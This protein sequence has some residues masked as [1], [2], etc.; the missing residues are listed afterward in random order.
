MAL[1]TDVLDWVNQLI[2]D[3][4]IDAFYKSTKWTHK[5][6]QILKDQHYECQRCKANGKVVKARTVHHKKYLKLFP[7]LALDD[8]NLEAICDACHYDEHHK[9]KGYTNDER[10]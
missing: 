5:Q 10:W 9:R 2:R 3:G 7:G 4:N 8:D 1:T 6:S